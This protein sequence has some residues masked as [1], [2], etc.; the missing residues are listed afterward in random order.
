[1]SSNSKD[2]HMMFKKDFLS[3]YTGHVPTK[4]QRFGS[5]TG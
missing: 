1:M 2:S 3:G 5:S 4:S